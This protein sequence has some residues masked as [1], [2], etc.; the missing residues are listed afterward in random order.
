V[1]DDLIIDSS[2]VHLGIESTLA[3]LI[4]DWWIWIV[5]LDVH[6]LCTCTALYFV[7]APTLNA[8][9]TMIRSL[10]QLPNNELISQ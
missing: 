5:G 6:A 10:I 7:Q 2:L 4:V 8:P 3:H 9:W 1:I